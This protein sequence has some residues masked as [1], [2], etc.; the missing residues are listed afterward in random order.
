MPNVFKSMD[1]VFRPEL[2]DI[3][4]TIMT[5][6]GQRCILFETSSEKKKHEEGI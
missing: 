4:W 5:S 3:N 6:G 1:L 2:S